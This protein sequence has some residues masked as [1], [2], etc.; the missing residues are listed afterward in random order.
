MTDLSP[1]VPTGT[2]QVEPISVLRERVAD[3]KRQF[4]EA[5]SAYHDNPTIENAAAMCV[6]EDMALALIALRKAE[7]AAPPVLE[8]AQVQAVPAGDCQIVPDLGP[9]PPRCFC[10]KPSVQVYRSVVTGAVG[11]G[12]HRYGRCADHPLGSE[13]PIAL[14]APPAAPE[15]T[16]LKDEKEV[17]NGPLLTSATPGAV[18]QQPGT[19][20]APPAHLAEGPHGS[21]AAPLTVDE[22]GIKYAPPSQRLKDWLAQI[23][24]RSLDPRADAERFRAE[25]DEACRLLGS[26]IEKVKRLE[27]RLAVEK[28]DH[29]E[30]S[31]SYVKAA[32]ER[33]LLRSENSDLQKKLE[34]LRRGIRE[35][36]HAVGVVGGATAAEPHLRTH[37]DKEELFLHLEILSDRLCQTQGFILDALKEGLT[38][39]PLDPSAPILP[40]EEQQATAPAPGDAMRCTGQLVH[41]PETFCPVHDR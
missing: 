25:R 11:G 6:G 22:D 29:A 13:K 12:D 24:K 21:A 37:D 17:A 40:L 14:F 7:R 26:E 23:P 1:S 19:A 31:A 28:T 15:K 20:P 3:L 41:D 10:G 39:V 30:A 34:G 27:Q 32:E 38:V 9:P 35:G 8:A 5:Q 4:A 33:A 18:S 36:D 16:A 2:A